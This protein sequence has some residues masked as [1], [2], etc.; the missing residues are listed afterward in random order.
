M[1]AL[2]ESIILVG[3]PGVGKTTVGKLLAKQTGM[4]F[5]DTDSL[6]ISVAGMP[7]Q[8]YITIY[9]IEDFR[10]LEEKV[11]SEFKPDS[12]VIIATGGSAVLY[13]IAMTNL[14]S[15]G[16]IVFLD[17][18]LPLI[19]SRIKNFGSRGIVLNGDEKTEELTN[20]PLTAVY[21]EREPLY[22]KYSDIRIHVR[23]IGPKY[24]AEDVLKALTKD[25]KN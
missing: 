9:G 15:L 14:K 19:R 23:G 10:K 6:I 25:T 12:P 17:A 8:D 18:D 11:L 4:E 1:T 21:I 2:N 5:I 20:D 13:D 3:M 24:V 7:L 22:Y 16:K